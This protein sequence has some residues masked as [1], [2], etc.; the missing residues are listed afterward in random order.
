MQTIIK[1]L[2]IK[3]LEVGLV[4]FV[5]ILFKKIKICYKKLLKSFRHMEKDIFS[6]DC[7]GG[8]ITW[9]VRRIER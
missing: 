9:G 6:L 4:S 2:L 3:M 1:V 8:S 5:Y 7:M